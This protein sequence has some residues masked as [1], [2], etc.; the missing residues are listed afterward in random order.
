[1]K[2]PAKKYRI[3]DID[4]CKGKTIACIENEFDSSIII[5][6]TDKTYIE[7]TSGYNG[8]YEIIQVFV[9]AEVTQRELNLEY[10]GVKCL[11]CE[12]LWLPKNFLVKPKSC[13]KCGSRKILGV[14][15][16]FDEENA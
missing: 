16:S 2:K 9:P 5:Y 12:H 11:K 6:F 1:M 4:A 10:F 7:F 8:S 15:D 3:Y 13:S 14:M